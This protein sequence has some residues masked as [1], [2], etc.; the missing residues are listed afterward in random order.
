MAL[1]YLKE[2]N[3]KPTKT[4]GTGVCQVSRSSSEL[5][6]IHHSRRKARKLRDQSVKTP[7]NLDILE[8]HTR[9]VLKRLEMSPWE[10]A[11]ITS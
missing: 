3:N 10:E 8:L 7:S 5:A 11:S 6:S 2:E 4:Q 9:A 1:F